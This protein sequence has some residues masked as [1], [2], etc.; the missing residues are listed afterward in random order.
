[1]KTIQCKFLIQPLKKSGKR[2]TNRNHKT[3]YNT[4][5]HN[6]IKKKIHTHTNIDYTIGSKV[7]YTPEDDVQKK[8]N[9]PKDTINK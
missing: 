1:M 9:A 2:A 4:H 3:I 6:F 8:E 5:S 7:L